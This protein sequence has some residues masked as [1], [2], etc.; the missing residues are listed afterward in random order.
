VK[1]A[2][3]S[4]R[5]SVKG[6]QPAFPRSRESIE[7]YAAFINERSGSCYHVFDFRIALTRL[8]NIVDHGFASRKDARLAAENIARILGI[9]IKWRRG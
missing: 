5:L 6:K 8:V 1:K 4:E 9:K 2:V 7:T 3:K